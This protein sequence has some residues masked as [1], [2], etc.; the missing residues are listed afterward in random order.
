ME[1]AATDGRA[2]PAS[3]D[4]VDAASDDSGTADDGGGGPVLTPAVRGAVAQIIVRLAASA[5]SS[6]VHRKAVYSAGD[7]A[8][9]F[10]TTTMSVYTAAL[11]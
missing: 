6:K 9:G 1:D 8:A 11:L 2:A 7:L 3:D 10:L 5:Q 4:A